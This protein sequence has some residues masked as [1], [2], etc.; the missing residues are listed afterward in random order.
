MLYREMPENGD[1]LSILGFGCMRLPLKE[2]K[3][4]EE[5]ARQQV[6]YAIDHG[7]NYI[8]TAWPYHMGESEPFV[9]R[10]L[11]DG[12]REKV[13]L[14]TKLPSWTVKSHEDMDRILN[15][16]L[17]RLGTDHVDYYLVHGL[18]GTLWDKMEKLEVLDFLDRAKADG[19]IINAGFSFHGSVDD[20]RRIVD[21]YP[22]TFC[23]I[24]YNFLDEKNQ[25]GTEGLE[26]AA[27]KGLGVIV[28]EPLR[29]GKLTN[30]IPPAVQD[31]WDET[32]VKRTPAEWSL[33]WI[34]NHPEV[35][36]VL[37]GMNEESHLEENLKTA[38]EAYPDSLTEDEL[39]LVKRVEQ[40]Y[41]ELMK[42]GCTGCRYCIPCPSGVDIPS[43]FEIYNN[44][45][46]SGN[47]KEAKLMYA[48]KPGGIIRG[49]VQGYASQCVQCGQCVEKCPQHLE[50]PSLLEAVVE[51][52][53][54]KD[55]KGWRVM[56]KKAF[57]KE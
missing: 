13:K 36:V 15:A 22:W 45:Y 11:A 19:R 35:T 40:K 18:V 7:V 37:S 5:R 1:E 38:D 14:A 10:A 16:Q 48:A 54:G 17:E 32:S 4:D 53:E 28:M 57:G 3:I 50:I 39:Q 8:D 31:I 21:A 6:R 12:Y 9:G 41:R 2:G 55:F 34:W 20:F 27:S 51:V 30:P 44:F 43:C 46:L 33:R 23:Q 49:D 42:V 52:F 56:A 26:Y 25:A 24:Q 47:E 29:G